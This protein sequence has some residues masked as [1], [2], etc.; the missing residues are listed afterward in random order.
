MGDAWSV[1]KGSRERRE[2]ELAERERSRVERLAQ[3]VKTT[4]NLDFGGVQ[5]IESEEGIAAAYR[6][7]AEGG[8]SAELAKAAALEAQLFGQKRPGAEDEP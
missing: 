2:R 5:R 4:K 7:A 3:A 6:R 8:L 1:D